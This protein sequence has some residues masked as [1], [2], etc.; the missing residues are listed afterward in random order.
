MTPAIRFAAA[1][2]LFTARVAVAQEPFLVIS[3][4]DAATIAGRPV[5]L[6]A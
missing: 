6:D 4:V 3:K 1:L 5:A 2:L